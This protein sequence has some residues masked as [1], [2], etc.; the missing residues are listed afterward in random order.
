MH[1]IIHF[2]GFNFMYDKSPAEHSLPEMQ[3]AKYCIVIL[4]GF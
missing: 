2:G 1:S 4:D 3:F